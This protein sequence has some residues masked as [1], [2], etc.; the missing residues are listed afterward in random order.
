MRG[1]ET[2]L[3]G[4]VINSLDMFEEMLGQSTR[5]IRGATE[6]SKNVIFNLLLQEARGSICLALEH[7]SRTRSKVIRAVKHCT[8]CG[9]TISA[10]QKS[11][12]LEWETETMLGCAINYCGP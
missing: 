12:T 1:Q 7:S 10:G 3:H 8:L 9:T 4:A 5:G 6:G 2:E 11:Q